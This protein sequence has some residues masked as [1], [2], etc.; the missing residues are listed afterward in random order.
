M[1]NKAKIAKLIWA[2]PKKKDLLWVRWVHGRYLK[3]KAWI[4]YTPEAD[5]SWYWKKICHIKDLFKAAS[6]ATAEMEWKGGEEYRV[7]QGYKLQLSSTIKVPWARVIWG[8]M[9][10][11]SHSFISWIFVQHRLPTK[12]R[13]ARFREQQLTTCSMCNL[14]EEDDTHLFFTCSYARMVWEGIGKWWQYLPSATSTDQL[15]DKMKHARGSRVSK[16]ISGAVLAATIYH[17]W[18]ARNQLIF[19][20]HT[21]TAHYTIEKIKDQVRHRFLLLHFQHRKYTK[22]IDTILQ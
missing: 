11:P 16:M 9:N 2:I 15:L 18:N 6:S 20:T 19:K 14:A 4:D 8:R 1:W 5:S 17:I 21:L 3:R 13:L 22:Y 7:T 12:K 10:V